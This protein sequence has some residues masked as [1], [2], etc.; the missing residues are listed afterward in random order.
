MN[1]TL[2]HLGQGL[3]HP[4][5]GAYAIARRHH[6][7][8]FL[9]L[10]AGIVTLVAWF[11]GFRV[12]MTASLPLGLYR[13]GGVIERGAAVSF[14]LESREYIGLAKARGYVGPGFC[15]GGLRPLGKEVYGLP[16]DVIGID[17]D[18]TI[19][20]NSQIIPGSAARAQD[21]RGG[22]MPK[23]R[24]RPGVIPP[25]QALLLSLHHTGSFDGRYFGLIDLA[26]CRKLQPVWVR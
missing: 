17:A 12:N 24:L 10:T 19:S 4:F 5:V 22:A 2:N 8:L 13:Q 7:K 11:A 15:P 16:G 3:C 20:I 9:F 26:D 1:S 21:S 14:C 18:G 25:G 6:S 23:S